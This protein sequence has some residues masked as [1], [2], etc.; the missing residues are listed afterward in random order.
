MRNRFSSTLLTLIL[1]VLFAACHP[2]PETR[3][4]T[5]T[6]IL[7]APLQ[8]SVGQHIAP[9]VFAELVM[10]AYGISRDEINVALSENGGWLLSWG[11]VGLETAA[12]SRKGITVDG[13]GI[14]FKSNEVTVQQFMGCVQSQPEWYQ[15]VY[16]PNPPTTGFRYAFSL[17]FPALGIVATGTGSDQYEKAPP[18]LNTDTALSRVFVG[19]PGSLPALYEQRWENKL[20]A[21]R[22]ALR[23]VPW[24]GKLDL[25]HFIEDREL[26]W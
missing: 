4:R 20:E 3:N 25:V 18:R 26:G 12:F 8:T 5:C 16:G 6:E 2:L 9:E 21:V 11:Q 13:I 15:A 17:Y 10:N 1:I 14:E 23:P 19:V 24:P 22:P 7:G